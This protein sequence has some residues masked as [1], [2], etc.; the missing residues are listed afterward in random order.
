M[1]EITFS[2][3]SNGEESCSIGK[4]HIHS[5]YNP[6]KEAERFVENL[7]FDFIPDN[8]IITEPALSYSQ[9]FLKKKYP[10]SKLY[11]IRYTKDFSK[12]DNLW[13]KVFYPEEK[14]FST[15]L[16]N[17]FG[18]EGI[19]SS[20]FIS[21]KPGESA[22]YDKY[23]YTWN[24]IKKSILKSR[25]VLQTRSY[26]GKKWLKNTLR[27]C[28]FSKN[29]IYIQKGTKPVIVCA[30]GRSLE[31]CMPFLKKHREKFFLLSVSSALKPLCC[32]NIIPDLCLSTDGGYWAKCHLGRTLKKHSVPLALPLEAACFAKDIK[33]SNIIPLSYG[34]GPAEDLIKDYNIPATKAERNGTVAGTAVRLAENLTDSKIFVCGL[35]LKENSGYAHTSPNELENIDAL[36]ENRLFTKETR[37]TP[38]TFSSASM[39]IYRDWFI[40]SNFNNRVYRLS[41]N[42]NFSFSLKNIEDVNWEYFLNYVNMSKEN[43]NP[44]FFSCNRKN[45]LFYNSDKILETL[46]K[47]ISKKE[48]FKT[49]LPLDSLMQEKFSGTSREEEHTKKIHEGI[50]EFSKTIYK[51][52][53]RGK[54][55]DL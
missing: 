35:D 37:I 3:A 18:D 25:T 10:E 47:N 31:G 54:K 48:W 9:K 41:N 39:K 49:L 21:W 27:F 43:V 40:N 16:F 13:D 8:I 17:F 26:F 55:Y 24:E 22:F 42:Y 32:N 29:Y 45:E 46:Q 38:R 52:Y 19:V 53:F 5:S 20:V 2:K 33:E 1:E 34:D 7:K 23:I 36:K 50:L 51:T 15:T 14:D 4:I 30:S 6:S 11:A 44:A 28:Y 12:Y